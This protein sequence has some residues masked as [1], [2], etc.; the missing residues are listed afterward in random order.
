M[1][2]KYFDKNIFVAFLLLAILVFV[3][4]A[5]A[6]YLN[7]LEWRSDDKRDSC[8]YSVNIGGL[9]GKEVTGTTIILV[10]IPATKEG[11]FLD[12]PSQ[13][14]LGFMQKLV[15][16]YIS[17]TPKSKQLGPTFENT[18]ELLDNKSS[19]IWKTFIEETDDGYMMGFRTNESTLDDISFGKTIVVDNIDI[20]DPINKSLILCPIKNLSNISTVTYG[21]Q[22]KYSSNP[23]YESY[24]Y[25][26]NNLRNESIN[27]EVSIRCYN[28]HTEW[29][30]EY[31]G[32]YK[33]YIGTEFQGFN[34]NDTGKVKVSVSL[35][36]SLK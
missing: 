12:P 4:I 32:S 25:L 22:T 30:E 11:Q 29:P 8:Y 18:S 28:D 23:D 14:D 33:S 31:R 1:D 13:Q 7:S 6:L 15:H 26:S 20:F 2:K 21:V 16:E 35:E 17:H 36:Q 24:V 19:G 27:F 5:N 10:P 3:F 9:S 34:V